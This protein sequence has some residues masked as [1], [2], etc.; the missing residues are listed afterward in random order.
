[1]GNAGWLLDLA[2][3]STVAITNWDSSLLAANYGSDL[4]DGVKVL[5]ISSAGPSS[6]NL[7]S[8]LTSPST[9]TAAVDLSPAAWHLLWSKISGVGNNAQTWTSGSATENLV[10][11][12]T[13]P[14]SYTYLASNTGTQ[15]T[16]IPTLGGVSTFPVEGNIPVSLQFVQVSQSTA[17]VKPAAPVVGTFQVDAFAN[18]T[19]TAAGGS[20]PLTPATI[21]AVSATGGTVS[22][23]FT[24][25]AGAN[26]RLRYSPQLG[27]GAVWTIAGQSVAGGGRPATLTD[28]PGGGTRFYL[29]ES[30]Q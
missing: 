23:T 24:T 30:Y 13:Q 11:A 12:P 3:G 4:T 20:P 21:T 18:I 15:P 28:T 16:L 26:Y 8:W 2:P 17:S 19:Y 10:L 9:N 7:S 5:L 22:V 25:V 27:P 14:Y 29:V 1:L 6:T